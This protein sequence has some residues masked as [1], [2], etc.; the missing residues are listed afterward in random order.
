MVG[1]QRKRVRRAVDFM[2]HPAANPETEVMMNY[3]ERA[4]R[5]F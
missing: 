2:N 4:S 3:L 1:A 5:G